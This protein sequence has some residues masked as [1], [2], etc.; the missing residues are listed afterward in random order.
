M[1]MKFSILC[2]LLSILTGCQNNSLF[3]DSVD[4][5][6]N[7]NQ[8]LTYDYNPVYD[9]KSNIKLNQHSQDHYKVKN[10]QKEKIEYSNRKIN[11][12]ME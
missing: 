6:Y 9:T 10:I 1:R 12:M 4:K 2:L 11:L 3:Y 8:Y 5:Q 7:Q